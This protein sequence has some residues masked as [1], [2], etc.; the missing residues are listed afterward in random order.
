MYKKMHSLTLALRSHELSSSNLYIIWQMHLQSLM[1][2][3]ITV[4][5]M[6]LQKKK[7]KNSK[8][9]TCSPLPSPSWVLCTCNVSS[10]FVQWFER[11][12]IHENTLL[13]SLTLGQGHT[14]CSSLIPLHYMAWSGVRQHS[15]FSGTFRAET[16]NDSV[17]DDNNNSMAEERFIPA[18]PTPNDKYKQEVQHE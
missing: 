4:N 11:R 12:C 8:K 17:S 10:C 14:I 7:K 6:H 9:K 16:W 3:R 13:N 5:E 18:T 15:A 2:L 1:L